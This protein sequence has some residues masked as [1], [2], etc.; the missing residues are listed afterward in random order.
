[1][2]LIIQIPCLHEERH[3]PQTLADLPH[4]LMGIDRI[5][6]LIIDDGSTDQTVQVA[7]E[8]GV[9]HIIQHDGNRGLAAAFSTGIRACL[10]RDADIIINTD[11]DNQYC[12]HDIA[13]LVRP[14]LR[15]EA[16]IVLGDRQTADLPTS[17]VQ[18]NLLQRIDSSAVR[19]MESESTSGLQRMVPAP[20]VR[21]HHAGT[22]RRRPSEFGSE[23][24]P[25]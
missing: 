21:N 4:T 23:V 24:V 6:T 16:S 17:L 10:L 7:C 22:S 18:K 11:G 20:P 13:R 9:D 8:Q 2:K 12:G 1:M 25:T 14:L 19:Q 3:L 5:E 15:N